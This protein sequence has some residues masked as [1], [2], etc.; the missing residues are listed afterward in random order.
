MSD[1]ATAIAAVMRSDPGVAAFL[2]V[3]ADRPAVFSADVTPD[4]H[5]GP[6]IVVGAPTATRDTSTTDAHRAA[7]TFR[8]RVYAPRKSGGVGAIATAARRALQSVDPSALAVPGQSV[9]GLI[10][11]R[12]IAA[13]TDAPSVEGRAITLTL[14]IKDL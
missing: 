7:L 14:Y 11:D 1:A 3:Y 8:I 13:P 6:A 12:P 5:S 4:D 10:V 2:P 9:L